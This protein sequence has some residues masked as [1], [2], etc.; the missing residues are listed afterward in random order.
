MKPALL[1]FL[2]V[3]AVL[4]FAGCSDSDSPTI[5]LPPSRALNGTFEGPL[6]SRIPGE[7]WST[8]ALDLTTSSERNVSGTITP[9][10]GSPRPIGGA[11]A[12]TSLILSIGDLPQQQACF[13]FTLNIFRFEFDAANEVSAFEGT[14]AGEC[15]GTLAGGFRMTRK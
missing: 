11:F 14:L 10:A 8:V 3:V 15:Q 4:P 5:A 6:P 13:A 9:K 1:R 7:D 2:L 12:G